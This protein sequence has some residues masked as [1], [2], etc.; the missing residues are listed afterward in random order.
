M[1]LIS[2]WWTE[3][4]FW[5]RDF[6]QPG[7][8]WQLAVIALS[9]AVAWTIARG[10]RR[11]LDARQGA[12]L[13]GF[14]K[15]TLRSVERIVYPLAAL[16]IIIIVRSVF[17]YLEQPTQLLVLANLLLLSLAG[18]RLLVYMLRKGF[19]PTPM[20]KAWENILSTTIWGIVALYLLGILPFVLQTLDSFA[21]TLAGNRISAL[22][23]INFLL[24][25][26]LLF[27][28]AIWF[29]AMI[30]RRMERATYLGAGLQ[31]ALGKV[32][33]FFLIGLAI[34]IAVDAVGIDL[35]AL[36]VFG[37]ALGVGLGFGLQRIASNFISGFLLLFDRSIKPGDVISVGTKFGWVHELH[38]R[39]IVV[40]DRDG[41]DTLI[42]NENLITSEV[43]NW[44]YADRNVRI[45]IPVQI[46]YRDDPELAMR[47][48]VGLARDNARVLQEP[49]PVGRLLE[50]GDN[51]IGLELRVWIN[52]PE[53]GVNN[54][55]SE[56][57]LG[58][59]QAFKDHNITIPFPQ[60]DVY[61]KSNPISG[62]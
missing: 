7:N 16:L 58:I 53:K 37:G 25:V 8:W 60:R 23:V 62:E 41:V 27:T 6:N 29:S 30:E 52:D 24:L 20:L 57:N 10:I 5:A 19:A 35:T 54:I 12:D 15:F 61:I 14:R 36:T 22:S 33:K 59:W 13:T 49:E 45:K 50:F 31:A 34:L 47:L 1:E 11:R 18:I 26:A 44:S 51:G 46:S 17:R 21:F 32:I 48:M 39:Y 4:L 9:L 43:I 42:P 28:F 2:N 38:A 40:R 55:R 56:L 3:L